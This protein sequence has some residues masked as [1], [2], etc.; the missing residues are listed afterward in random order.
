MND[1]NVSSESSDDECSVYESKTNDDKHH[2]KR[3]LNL[4]EPRKQ[5][6]ES[7]KYHHENSDEQEKLTENLNQQDKT[8]KQRRVESYGDSN[9]TRSKSTKRKQPH[10]NYTM[11][12]AAVEVQHKVYHHPKPVM[13]VIRI[14][15]YR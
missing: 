8:Q 1:S 5:I 9:A 11:D 10:S 15:K 7:Q 13:V 2:S 4:R 6:N 14:S 3:S 12:L